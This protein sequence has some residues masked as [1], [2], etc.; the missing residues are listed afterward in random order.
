MIKIGD[1][2]PKKDITKG[3]VKILDDKYVIK[4]KVDNNIFSYLET[5]NFNYFPEIIES[6]E[7]YDVTNYAKDIDYPR[8]QKLYDLIDL[9]TLLHSKTTYFKEIDES[10]FS[11]LYEDISNNILYLYSY[12]NDKATL[13]ESKTFYS[14]SEYLLLRSINKIFYSLDY[15]KISLDELLETKEK[16]MRTC[17]IHNNLDLNHYIKGDRD[18]LIS[19]NKAKFDMPIFDLYKLFKRNK[20]YN[21]IDLLDRYEQNYPLLEYEKKLLLIMLSMPDIIDDNKSEI[22]KTKEIKQMIIN[23]EI[24]PNYL[25]NKPQN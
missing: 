9:T 1:Y 3:K 16:K 6:D 11:E 8:E 22:E 20:T 13:I 15:A 14:P 12:Y 23:L 17:M 24:L 10:K 5:R 25:D 18:Y 21:Y 7:K 2:N 19:W 4:E